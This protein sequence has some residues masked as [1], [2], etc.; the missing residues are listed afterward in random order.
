VNLL[1][2]TDTPVVAVSPETDHLS[3]AKD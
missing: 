1:E 2:K 3:V